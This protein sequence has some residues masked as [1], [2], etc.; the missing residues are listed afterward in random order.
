MSRNTQRIDR[1]LKE[2]GLFATS[3]VWKPWGMAMEMQGIEGGW[4][5][6]VT[7]PIE[8]CEYDF[9]GLSTDDLLEEI[10]QHSYR[11][12]VDFWGDCEYPETKHSFFNDYGFGMHISVH[13]WGDA[14]G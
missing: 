11:Q 14:N 6:Y 7:D 9:Q 2:L 4:L 5:V 8:D 13:K 1:A 10:Y 3:I 12:A